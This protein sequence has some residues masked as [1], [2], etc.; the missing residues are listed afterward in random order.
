VIQHFV[1]FNIHESRAYG[2]RAHRC[3][4]LPA[5]RTDNAYDAIARR[6]PLPQH[7]ALELSDRPA[8]AGDGRQLV[9]PQGSASWRRTPSNLLDHEAVAI[10]SAPTPRLLRNVRS[11]AVG[12]TT[13]S[14]RPGETP[15]VASI[16]AAPRDLVVSQLPNGLAQL[17][18]RRE[19]V[20]VEV[21]SIASYSPVR[22]L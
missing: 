14:R 11:R 8:V 22:S 17:C 18:A 15:A 1:P 20:C 4:I 6:R 21:A 5:S 2:P 9:H 13:R 3:G 19:P 12:R 16:S 10:E 7:L